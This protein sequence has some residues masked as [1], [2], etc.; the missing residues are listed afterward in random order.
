MAFI[1]AYDVSSEVTC[2]DIKIS[3]RLEDATGTFA[4]KLDCREQGSECCKEHG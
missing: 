4:F 3:E 1:P 2:A